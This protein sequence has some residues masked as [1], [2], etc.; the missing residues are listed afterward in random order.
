MVLV[1]KK[2]VQSCANNEFHSQW[3]LFFLAFPVLCPH[4][5]WLIGG[6]RLGPRSRA[7]LV[8][9]CIIGVILYPLAFLLHRP[10][11]GGSC[12]EPEKAEK[13]KC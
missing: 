11:Q 5:S 10:Y 7:A 3:W 1:L 2:K 4:S 12:K 6:I 13:K 9:Y 8:P